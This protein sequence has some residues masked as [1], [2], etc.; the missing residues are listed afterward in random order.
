MP[1]ALISEP[2]CR[3]HEMGSHHP[4]QP[5]RLDSIQNRLIASGLDMVLLHYDAPRASLDQLT[6]VHDEDY[7][8]TIFQAAPEQGLVWLDGDTAM[9]PHTLDAAL[10]AAGAAALGVDLVMRG[11]AD[12]VFCNVRPPGH[13]AERHRA[14]G[15]C[16]FNN[17]A[18]GAYHAL[19]RYRLERVA[20][21]DFDVH[22]GNGTEDIVL[23]DPRIL[24]CSSFQH[25]FYPGTGFD[26]EADNIVNIPLPRLTDGAQYREAVLQAWI[27]RLE[28]FAPQLIMVSAGFDG[29]R[30]DDMAQFNLLDSDYAWISEQIIQLA[31][32]SGQGRIVSC[33]E[34]GYELRALARSVEAHIK[35]LL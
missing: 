13:H 24:F 34:G 18:V 3:L 6:A 20:I 19:N 28:A 27:P 10:H 22:H 14:M 4:E 17:V 21:I 29:H 23:G 35:A 12:Q 33:L 2:A 16:I 9:N 7:V 26:T 25:P 32:L 1:I 8:K 15:F 31:R 30:D 5:A 11:E